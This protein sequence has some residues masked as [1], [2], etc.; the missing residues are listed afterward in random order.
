[1]L[2]RVKSTV[3]EK[4]SI[5]LI[6][7]FVFLIGFVFASVIA[8]ADSYCT[9]RINYSYEDG[10]A[11]HDPYVAV[12]R[13]GENLNVEVTNPVIPGYVPYTALEGGEVARKTTLDYPD[14]EGDDTVTIYYLPDKVH[15]KVRYFL[16]N[17]RDDLYTENLSLSNDYYEKSGYTGTYPEE[18]E[19]IH[20]DG[21]T[22]LFHE[23]DSIAADGST[24]FKLYYDRNYYLVNFDLGKGGYGVEPV[25]AKHGA[26]YNISTPKRTGYDFIGWVK[27]NEEGQYLNNSGTPITEEE[28]KD[29]AD[30]F[31]SGIVPKGNTY[32]KAVWKPI[33]TKYTI[34]YWIENP[35]STL[36][37]SALDGKSAQEAQDL[38]AKNYSVATSYAVDN[39]TSGTTLTYD[40]TVLSYDL[41]EHADELQSVY[42]KMS[43]A[44]KKDLT[45]NSRY[46]HLNEKASSLI[47]TQKR[48]DS[49]T[50]AGDGST[51]IN[52]YYERKEMTLK[53]FYAKS[54][55]GTVT[56]DEN[57]SKGLEGGKVSLTSGTK[58]FSV[59]QQD[60]A[61]ATFKPIITQLRNASFQRPVVANLPKIVKG[62]M[63]VDYIDDTEKNH[64]YWFYEF[65]VKY[66]ASLHNV[67]YND[68]FDT[69]QRSDKPN[70]PNEVVRFGSWA[71]QEGSKY[72]VGKSNFTVKG[73]FEKLDGDILLTDTFINYNL[74]NTPGFDYTTLYFAAS[75]DNTAASSGDWNGSASKVFNFT[76]KNY[77]QLLPCEDYVIESKGWDTFF[78]GGEYPGGFYSKNGFYFEPGYWE[79]GQYVDVIENNG[80]RY[81]LKAQNIV[82]T[83]DAGGNYH[84]LSEPNLSNEVKKNQT[85][86][87]MVGYTYITEAN[88]IKKNYTHYYSN[89]NEVVT[90]DKNL[91]TYD[92]N[93]LSIWYDNDGEGGFDAKHHCDVM[94]FYNFNTYKLNYYNY[95]VIQHAASPRAPY[96]GPFNATSLRYEN[97]EF[98]VEGLE[99]YY[100]FEGWYWDPFYT[101]KLNYDT[102]RMPADDTTFYARWLPVTNEVKFYNDYR[103]YSLNQEP[104]NS[105]TVDYNSLIDTADVPADDPDAVHKL[106]PLNNAMFAGWYYI[107][108]NRQPVRFDPETLPVTRDLK[109]Y[110]E[111]VSRDTA[112]YQVT[113]T[114][115][116]TGKEVA[117]PSTGTVFVSKTRTF[118]AKSGSELNE[119][120][121]WVDG[122][123]N[124]WPTMSSHSILIE[125]NEDGKEFEPNTYNFEYIHKE[126]VWY[127]VQYIDKDSGE[128]LYDTQDDHTAFA[129]VTERAQYIEGYV[130]DKISRSIVLSASVN[131]DSEKAKEEELKNNR[132]IFFYTKSNTGTLYQ[133]DHYIQNAD[134]SSNYELYYSENQT[135]QI[136]DTVNASD[137][138]SRD[139]CTALL[140]RGYTIDESKTSIKV[141]D[142]E[143]ALNTSVTLDGNVTVISVYYNR[144][145]YKYT[146]KYYDYEAEKLYDNDPTLWDG[147]IKAP[148]TFD[149]QPVGK[150]VNVDAPSSLRYNDA[151]Y[152]R[153]SDR[154]L[155]VTIRTDKDPPETNIIKVYYKRDSQRK[156]SYRTYC[157]LDA[158]DAETYAVLS[159]SQ[160]LVEKAEEI[161]GCTV[162]PMSDDELESKYIFKGWYLDPINYR[163][164]SPISTSLTYKPNEIPGADITYYAVFEQVKVH[165][166]VEI[167]YN[168]DGVYTNDESSS[169]DTDGNMTGYKVEFESPSGYK[170]GNDT[171]YAKN[172]KFKFRIN[173]ND[174]RLYK[175]EFTGWYEELESGEIIRHDDNNSMTVDNNQRVRNYRYIAMFKKLP[176]PDSMNYEIKFRFKTRQ[177]GVQD[178]VVKDTLT[179]D[180]LSESLN[181][182][183]AYEL[184]DEFIM[185]LAPFESNHGETL[186]WTDKNIVKDSKA[187]PDTMYTVVTAEQEIKKV[188]VNYRL[189]ESGAYTTIQTTIGANRETDQKLAAL[190]LRDN[191]NFSYWAIRK[192]EDGKVIAK[193]YDSWFTFCIMDDY[194]ISPVFN[195]SDSSAEDTEIVLTHLDYSRNRWTDEDGNLFPNGSTD[196]MYTD[197]EIAFGG[198][199]NK[200]RNDGDYTAGVVL[201]YCASLPAD[202]E[203]VEGKDYNFA[204]NEANLKEAIKNKSTVYYYNDIKR[205][206]ISVNNIPNLSLTNK[207]RVEF[208]KPFTNNYTESNGTKTYKNRNYVLKATAYLIDKDQNV[209]LSNSVYVC[210]RNIGSQD[211]ALDNM[212]VITTTD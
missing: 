183:G 135:A 182:K 8:Y 2:T 175:Y 147:E 102:D 176:L 138:Y 117:P 118:T 44:V 133:I 212:K 137:I 63:K 91:S 73:F 72:K 17:I 10:T 210:M 78:N 38:L 74:K 5:F 192:S 109:L 134:D 130:P 149:A 98:P 55:G 125:S 142:E 1:M 132:I 24:E 97:P 16:Q 157:E 113:Y 21:F 139:T 22:S 7:L 83:I 77:T 207:N 145:A 99:N 66:G 194:F 12:L 161:K 64:R 23:P 94:F 43:P 51:Q 59:N 141:N 152:T 95:N 35:E 29:I 196:L 154:Q 150:I 197:F 181:D 30:D 28:A 27:S 173:K 101:K 131:S 60:K 198:E 180:K 41:F 167:R 191:K 158:D 159:S 187:S 71:V 164:D 128:I 129:V 107:D 123:A 37:E 56:V 79:P 31:S 110:A 209:T 126:K 153:I 49:I 114:E 53:F 96:D 121:K 48:S 100:V 42:E 85:A 186:C 140:D 165:M 65:K 169:L 179:K 86:V 62:G 75:W 26:T 25:Y 18:L 57:G 61:N 67:W 193:C 156:L 148:E 15:Y 81:G 92:I 170:C 115:Q 162:T 144:K 185:A 84:T 80:V 70:Q 14:I 172:S 93:P 47:F 143:T 82:E 206:S 203:F 112:K 88:V 58:G 3:K 155:T 87:S 199:N 40:N 39:V 32:Y 20:F 200:L 204:S 106:N 76:Y 189:N 90:E 119:E 178:F 171:P 163:T 202:K 50:V 124:W 120:H 151:N 11:A 195:D 89:G 33:D 205:R 208:A 174:E 108:E 9:V 104:V 69:Q 136:G 201:E 116:G 211:N 190:D 19:N 13:S 36:T 166:N 122:E 45:E 188:H 68:A 146:V 184:S 54:E 46:Y 52:V 127:R 34:I 111:W 160:E 4:R 168:D 105:C 6:T 103:S 177:Y